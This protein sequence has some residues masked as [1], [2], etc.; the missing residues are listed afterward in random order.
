MVIQ[1]EPDENSAK[2]VKTLYHAALIHT[3]F[4]VKDPLDFSK[5]VFGLINTAMGVTGE[6]IEEIEVTE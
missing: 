4:V 1:D 3:G 6:E 2:L 5:S